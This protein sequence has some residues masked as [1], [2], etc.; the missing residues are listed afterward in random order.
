MF[1]KGT[2]ESKTLDYFSR[3]LQALKMK[4]QASQVGAARLTV[5]N[6]FAPSCGL[7]YSIFVHQNG[8][9]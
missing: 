4:I 3:L 9:M 8:C 7:Q 6:K 5:L 1:P 2:L